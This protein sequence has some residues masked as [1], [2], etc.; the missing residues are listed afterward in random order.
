[1]VMNVAT[2][3]LNEIWASVCLLD[4]GGCSDDLANAFRTVWRVSW[5]GLFVNL[6]YTAAIESIISCVDDLQLR[7]RTLFHWGRLLVPE[8]S[9]T[10]PGKSPP[11]P[12][13]PESQADMDSRPQV[14]GRSL[15]WDAAQKK[16]R[17]RESV[18]D[19]SD[20]FDAVWLYLLYLIWFQQC[21]VVSCHFVKQHMQCWCTTSTSNSRVLPQD[22]SAKAGA[23]CPWVMA[24]D[25]QR[26]KWR[27]A[28]RNL[29]CSVFHCFLFVSRAV[30]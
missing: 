12:L 7:L 19:T 23:K 3:S 26:V 25:F 9:V 13:F 5:N 29:R 20:A 1:M 2:Y 4:P 18:S 24:T 22:G 16:R 8:H 30:T 11:S 28:R 6:T 14:R 17:L 10:P 21:A 15:G 27:R